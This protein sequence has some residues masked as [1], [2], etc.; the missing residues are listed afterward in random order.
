MQ[1]KKNRIQVRVNKHNQKVVDSVL[2]NHKPF[3]IIIGNYRDISVQ[4]RQLFAH[5]RPIRF[6]TRDR[7]PAKA[8]RTKHL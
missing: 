3:F 1:N 2:H 6:W 7:A 8:I 5:F 4:I